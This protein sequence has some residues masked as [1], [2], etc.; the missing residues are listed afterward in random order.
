MRLFQDGSLKKKKKKIHPGLMNGRINVRGSGSLK[1]GLRANLELFRY[2]RDKT[3]LGL[4][5]NRNP[6]GIIVNRFHLQATNDQC[7]HSAVILI[8]LDSCM[9]KQYASLLRSHEVSP[10]S[11]LNIQIEALNS[12]NYSLSLMSLSEQHHQYSTRLLVQLLVLHPSLFA[13]SGR[14]LL[15]QDCTH[16]IC[17]A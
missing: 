14:L 11:E 2:F 5:S 12:L 4:S 10:W 6:N 16:Q 13:H 15:T 3:H 1:V 17:Q 7:L 8:S 9:H